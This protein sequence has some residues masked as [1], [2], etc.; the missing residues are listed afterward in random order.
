VK[1]T[2][3][4]APKEGGFVIFGDTGLGGINILVTPSGAGGNVICVNSGCGAITTGSTTGG[5]TISLI[6]GDFGVTIAGRVVVGGF[7]GISNVMRLLEGTRTMLLSIFGDGGMTGAGG[8][9][10]GSPVPI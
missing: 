6:N 7:T 10:V 8:R 3:G 2:G 5:T 4:I 9:S 1:I